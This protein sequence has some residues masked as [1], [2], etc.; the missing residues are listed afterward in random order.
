[1]SGKKRG[2]K[3]K[4]VRKRDIA[5]WIRSNKI[6]I[7]T[8]LYRLI[9]SSSLEFSPKFFQLLYEYPVIFFNPTDKEVKILGTKTGINT[10]ITQQAITRFLKKAKT[11]LKEYSMKPKQDKIAVYYYKNSNPISY[12]VLSKAQ[13]K[14]IFTELAFLF[15]QTL[16]ETTGIDIFQ[17]IEYCVSEEIEK[18]NSE[19]FYKIWEEHNKKQ[20]DK[21]KE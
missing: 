17:I 20:Q 8:L 13:Q 5:F 2:R 3:P 18:I 4:S 14:G 6:G 1:M 21:Q 19:T 16:S 15:I 12:S 10:Q 9:L 7:S 11:Y